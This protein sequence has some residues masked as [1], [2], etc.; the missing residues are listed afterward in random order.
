[1]DIT[2][3]LI[4]LFGI[5]IL[6]FI[7]WISSENKQL[8]PW[9]V[10]KWGLGLQFF[11]GF[12]L[13]VAPITRD[14]VVYLNNGLN[15][16]LDASEGGARFVFGRYLVPEPIKLTC[17][18]SAGSPV[19]TNCS[20]TSKLRVEKK[21]VIVTSSSGTE[22]AQGTKLSE[23]SAVMS[24]SGANITGGSKVIGFDK[25]SVTLDKPVLKDELKSELVASSSPATS[26][27]PL[28]YIFAFRALPMVIFFSALINLFY[29]LNLI[30]PVVKSFAV[31][32]QK[33]MRISGA[34]SLSGAANIFVGI[35]SIIAIKPFLEKMTRSEM[36]AVLA[37]CFGSI[38]ST[39]LGIYANALR[40]SFPA[41]TG[42]LMAASILTIPA[43]FVLAKIIVPEDGTP[44]TMGGIPDD[45]DENLK[46]QS[47]MDSFIK[48]AIDGVGMAVGIAA[49]LIAMLAVIQVLTD[50][51]SFAVSMVYSGEL[52][53]SKVP[54]HNSIFHAFFGVIFFP[55]TALT[56]ASL[57][58]TEL[59]EASVMIGQRFFINAIPSYNA[60]PILHGQGLITDRT[61]LIVS[62]VLCGFTSLSSVGIFVGGL[63]NLIP[64]R[65]SDVSSVT[66]KALWAGTL[67]TLMTGCIAG[68]FDFGSPSVLGR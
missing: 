40:T 13:F 28:A 44:L 3:N 11:L 22:I 68:L 38:A 66:W 47:Y 36:C 29:R 51:M 55:L 1:M 56:G 43:C 57:N 54:Y 31:L 41:I 42:H 49:V 53:F 17:N 65:S 34:E 61:M 35:E 46:K 58:P 67:A 60:L 19:L 2:L 50:V 37:S 18:L 20:N 6:C 16:L 10:I 48:G 26:D 32:F 7:A 64:N 15:V 52:Q 62:Y 21:D 33:T 9:H 14:A 45:T 24:I 23:I 63:T 27:Y 8:I 12:L 39:V 25:T 4:S 59:W 5:F 30:Q